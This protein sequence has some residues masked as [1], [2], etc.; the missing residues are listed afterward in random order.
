MCGRYTLHQSTD[1]LRKR[2][3]LARVPSDVH[4]NYNVAPGQIMPVIVEDDGEPK[5]ELMKWGLIPSWSKDPRI[6]YKLINA[7][8]D[9]IFEKPI[10]RKVILQKRA[11]IPADGFYEWKRDSDPKGLKQPFY[12]RPKDADLFAFAGVWE[13]WKDV[14]GL[15]W[16]TFSIITTEPN[17]EMSAVHNRMPV[18]LHQD[19]E[20]SWL[21]H[22][23]DND[24]GS[25]EPLLRPYE[26]DGLEMYEVSRDVNATRNNDKKLIYPLGDQ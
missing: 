17:K 12:I 26:D 9:T 18:I 23:H 4:E 16:K 11:L 3:N 6:G 2:F 24:R 19:D 10:W 13:V 1:K 25:I 15:E 7:R 21:S 8:D 22:S 5:V 20:S 14:E